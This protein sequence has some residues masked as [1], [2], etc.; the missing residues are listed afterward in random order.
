[1]NEHVNKQKTILYGFMSQCDVVQFLAHGGCFNNTMDLNLLKRRQGT[2]ALALVDGQTVI[3]DYYEQ[4][5]VK[6]IVGCECGLYRDSPLADF[7]NH[8]ND[9]Q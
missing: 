2:C 1:M 7:I 9:S 8:P 5:P 4:S 6:M 3:V